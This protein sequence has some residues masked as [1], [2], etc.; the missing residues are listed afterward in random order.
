M[1]AT[2]GKPANCTAASAPSSPA[3]MM[4]AGSTSKTV[5]SHPASL[6][7]WQTASISA[8][9]DSACITTSISGLL[10]TG[11]LNR[12][13]ERFLL[14]SKLGQKCRV[15]GEQVVGKVVRDRRGADER[16]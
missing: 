2:P 5:A 12:Y 8:G 16:M 11:I 10:A 14:H 3:T 13:A 7:R 6:A 9:D 4:T 1:R 15:R